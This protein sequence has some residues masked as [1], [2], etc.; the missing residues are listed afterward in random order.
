MEK[1][2]LAKNLIYQRKRKGYS[3]EELSARTQ[4]NVRTIKRIEKGD[5]TPHLQ[6]IKLIATALEIEVDTLLP[7]ENPQEESIQKKWLLL[8]HGAPVLGFIIPFCNVLLPLFL[9]IHKRQDNRLYDVHGVKVIN[10][11]ITVLILYALSI[12]SLLTIEKWGFLIFIVL[13]PICVLIVILNIFSAIKNHNCYY[14]LSI[15]FVRPKNVDLKIILPLLLF[16]SLANCDSIKKDVVTRLDDT[17]ISTDTLTVKI[18]ELMERE[19]VSG[20]AITVFNNSTAVYKKAFGY[21]DQPNK[22]KLSDSTNIYGASLSKAVFSVLVMDLVEDGVI[23]LDTPLQSYLPKKIYEYAPQTRWHDDYSALKADSL[24]QKITARMCLAHT[25]GFQNWRSGES[26]LKVGQEPGLKHIY[27]GEG[28][29][30]LQV[31]LEKITGKGLQQLAQERIFVPLN[32]EHP[33]YEWKGNFSDNFAYGHDED[34]TP[35]EK[36]T[37]NEPR[38]ASTLETTLNDYSIFLEAVLQE[39]LISKA[40]YEQL[41]S[42]QI[43]VLEPTSTYD[44]PYNNSLSF[45]SLNAKYALGWG[46][47][48][49]PYGKAVF[50][51][52]NG[53]GFQHYSVLFPE[54]GTGILIMTN[55]RNGRRV[56]LKILELALKDNFST[57]EIACVYPDDLQSSF[58]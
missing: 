53:S 8:M 30:Y 38:A 57:L 23:D 34:G 17:T 44:G 15:P 10:F 18:N 48:D 13:I 52:G 49:T 47:L 37:D 25:S 6:T 29:V 5:S 31:V 21:R 20:L 19:N 2:S 56:F 7:I 41:F 58:S 26:D 32:M 39:K 16:L 9:W 27:S 4:V 55:S 3:Q 43:E 33:A 50:K 36:D 11:H 12:I 54:V 46:Y 22:S 40:S 14:P 28:F 35:Y 24:Y 51:G 42:P 1:Q 45:E